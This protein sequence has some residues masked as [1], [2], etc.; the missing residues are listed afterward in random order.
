MWHF[1]AIAFYRKANYWD[2]NCNSIVNHF[3]PFSGYRTTLWTE[4]MDAMFHIPVASLLT[5]ITI[6]GF[7]LILEQ[8]C[9]V[10]PMNKISVAG[11]MWFSN[12]YVS[13]TQKSHN[14]DLVQDYAYKRILLGL[15]V[16]CAYTEQ[17][18][19]CHLSLTVVFCNSLYKGFY[20]GKMQTSERGRGT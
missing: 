17:A 16:I 18:G 5:Q 3:V 6:T 10:L 11:K 13:A 8:Y 9:C 1:E 19:C 14:Y 4:K 15:S 2:F 20:L 12:S 7:F